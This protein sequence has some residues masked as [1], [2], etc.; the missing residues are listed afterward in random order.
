MTMDPLILDVLHQMLQ[1]YHAL[2][3]LFAIVPGQMLA[4]AAQPRF[5]DGREGNEATEDPFQEP[6]RPARPA[7]G[8]APS[9][10]VVQSFRPNHHPQVA[11]ALAPIQVEASLD[12]LPDSQPSVPDPDALLSTHRGQFWTTAKDSLLSSIKQDLVQRPN[13]NTV[14]KRLGCSTLD[15]KNRCALTFVPINRR[16]RPNAHRRGVCVSL[17]SRSAE[18]QPCASAKQGI[19]DVL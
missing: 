11:R 16:G 3:V 19:K 6:A 9:S 18:L 8:P 12:R 7:S 13:W 1:A 10:E 5:D 14:A 15:A 4:E 2:Q 17:I